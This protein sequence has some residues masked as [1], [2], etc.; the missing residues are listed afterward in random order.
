MKS[1]SMKI[2]KNKI[3]YRKAELKDIQLLIDSRIIFL[4]EIQKEYSKSKEIQL[5]KELKLYFEKALKNKTYISWIAEYNKQAIGFGAVA[6]R[7]QPGNFKYVSGRVGYVLNMFTLK[8]FRRLGICKTIL[9]L[10]IQ[11]CKKTNVDKLEM[12]ATP[13]GETVYRQFGFIEP[14]DKALEL[15]IQ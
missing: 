5:R 15:S 4:K 2:E 8:G 1:E 11:E 7:Q 9:E 12:L 10:L 3:H 6:I 14:H 13:E